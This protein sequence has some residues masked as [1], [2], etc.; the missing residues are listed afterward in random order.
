MHDEI[1]QANAEVTLENNG[2]NADYVHFILNRTPQDM[3]DP[4]FWIRDFG[5]RTVFVN[6]RHAFLDFTFD[7]NQHQRS[8]DVPKTLGSF[9]QFPVYEFDLEFS[10]GN[11]QVTS[12][13]HGFMTNHILHENPLKTE[14]EVEEI[15]MHAFGLETLT[16]Y[17]GLLPEYDGTNHIDMWLMVLSNR[18]ILVGEYLFGQPGYVE[19][20]A[21]VSDLLSKGY[22][23][24]RIKQ[25][26]N[27]MSVGFHESY[28]NSIIVNDVVLIPRHG[29]F[30]DREAEITWQTLMPRKVI[31]TVD[32]STII[33]YAGALHCVT[34]QIYSDH[35]IR[36][37]ELKTTKL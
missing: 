29:T 24:R 21:A 14:D 11:L 31:I 16:I 8:N 10:G 20:E 4:Q 33:Q 37:H 34:Q 25:K 15:L 28:T 23:V 32:T 22:I 1:Q 18:E 6:G 26:A 36:L 2:V 5:P 3:Q 13:G 7:K 27:H 19:T 12:D 17:K 30:L 9:L 35:A